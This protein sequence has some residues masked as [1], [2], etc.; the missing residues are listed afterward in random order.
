[1]SID[2]PRNDDGYFGEPDPSGGIA[3]I[4]LSVSRRRRAKDGGYAQGR[5][6]RPPGFAPFRKRSDV[7][8]AARR[9]ANMMI[10]GQIDAQ[11]SHAIIHALRLVFDSMRATENIEAEFKLRQVA[12]E[13]AQMRALNEA[14]YQRLVDL[15]VVPPLQAG[16]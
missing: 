10:G 13:M 11:Q 1:M 8:R 4:N 9:V 2:N 15:G 6:G 7:E 14:L 12:E 5:A 16:K 3:G